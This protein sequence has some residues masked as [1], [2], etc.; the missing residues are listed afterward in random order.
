MSPKMP[1]KFAHNPRQGDPRRALAVSR[2]STSRVCPP[3]RP[4]KGDDWLH[5][6]KWDG[7]A[8][9]LRKQVPILR[10]EIAELGAGLIDLR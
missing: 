7:L 1:A 8:R 2:A 5:E 3:V 4:P 9:E 6:P 10:R